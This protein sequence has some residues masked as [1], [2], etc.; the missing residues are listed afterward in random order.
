MKK[1]IILAAW[2]WKR[3]WAEL[4][5][6]LVSV[7][8]LPMINY[9]INS[10]IKSKVD[11]NPIIVVSPDNINIIKKYI[12]YD[13]CLFTE[14]DKQLGTWHALSC[15]KNLIENNISYIICLYWDHPFIKSDTIKKIAENQT[16]IITIITTSVTNFEDWQKNFYHWW[17]IVRKNWK[18]EKIVEYKDANDEEK[19]IKEVNPAIYCFET[20]WLWENIDKLQNNNAQK[21]YYLTDLIK[22]GFDQNIEINSFQIDPKEAM[23]INSK[24]ELEIAESII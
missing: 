11:L 10:I 19:N 24:E 1:I 21:E 17:R 13:K 8:W 14:Q 18:I 9:L 22:V 5:K 23:W 20:K 15:A 6:V 7:K 12:T 4:P 16:W 3:M 2:K